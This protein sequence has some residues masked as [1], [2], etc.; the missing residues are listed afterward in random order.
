MTLVLQL[1]YLAG[2]LIVRVNMMVRAKV[3]Y[4]A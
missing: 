3:M 1:V 2:T 4:S